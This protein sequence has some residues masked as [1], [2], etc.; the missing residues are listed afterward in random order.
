MA[1]EKAKRRLNAELAGGKGIPF[2]AAAPTPVR[3]TS[4]QSA[5]TKTPAEP[6]ETDTE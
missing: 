2:R 5:K 4:A 3:A 1:N 6:Q